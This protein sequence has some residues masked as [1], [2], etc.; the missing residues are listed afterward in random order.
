MNK[1][2]AGFAVVVIASF[3]IAGAA[4]ASPFIDM[5]DT[6]FFGE[7]FEWYD[8][9]Y[10][11]MAS[12]VWPVVNATTISGVDEVCI[13]GDC[14]AEWPGAGGGGAGKEGD[15]IYL[16]NDTTTM[17]LNETKLNNTIDLRPSGSSFNT[18][19]DTTWKYFNNIT[20]DVNTNTTTWTISI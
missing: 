17:F 16:Y 20:F 6:E 15:G 1:K 10:A 2:I 13:A 12:I 14:R 18:S 5:P 9:V 3:L 8:E 11:L 4:R 19:Y 7:I